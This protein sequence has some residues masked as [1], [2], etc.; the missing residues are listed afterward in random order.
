MKKVILNSAGVEKVRLRNLWVYNREIKNL[1]K[2]IKPGEIVKI[3]SPSGRFLATGYV[4]PN[5]KITVRI[6]SFED[7]E[8]DYRFLKTRIQ[9][10]YEIRKPL[11]SKTDAF[12]I[13]HA[14]ADFLPG[15]VVDYYAG[16]LS[17]Q[18][19]TAG[20]E[21][22]RQILIDAL[23]DVVRPKGIVEKSDKT[24]RQLEGLPA[25]DRVIYGDIPQKI[26][27]Q[28]NGVVFYIKLLDSQKT[29]F[30]LDQRRNR[31]VVASYVQKDFKILDLFSN[32]GGFG[33]H[34]AMKGAG[35]V[36][37]VDI[38]PTATG[39]IE[40]NLKLN[41][42]K[43]Y[44]IVKKDVFDFVKE[45]LKDGQRYDIIILDPPPFAKSKNEKEGALRGFKYLI[46]SCLKLL[47][48]GGYLAVFSC[49]HH[50]SHQDLLD[51]TLQALEDTGSVVRY[52]QYL[53]Q[54][55]D[56]PYILN[57]PNSLYLKGFLLQKVR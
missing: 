37:F 27:I 42:I 50:I 28:E 15:F 43:N 3:Y 14:E 49:S 30:Y 21:S 46:L 10:A 34:C 22:L 20:M 9:Q 2:N 6:L 31:Q 53:S 8:V 1:S 36:K 4:N 11:F 51:T 48:H 39:L 7:I 44:Q 40:E 45:E 41:S 5:S 17:V 55:I 23:V 32:T 54:D 25:E 26:I 13:V 19:N 24:S 38:S 47:E 52:V 33:V 29:G 12:R 35:F 18:I 56:H 16:Y 57:V